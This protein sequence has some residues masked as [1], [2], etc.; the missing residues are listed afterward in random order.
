NCS[1]GDGMA[2]YTFGDRK[3]RGLRSYFKQLLS[4]FS[5]LAKI[6]NSETWVV[7]IV[8]FSDPEWQLPKYLDIMERAG[9]TEIQIREFKNSPDGRLWRSVPHRK[10]YAAYQ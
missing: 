4:A 3:Q 10:W 8:G 2:Y 1:D 9:F 6:A 5:S 7:Q